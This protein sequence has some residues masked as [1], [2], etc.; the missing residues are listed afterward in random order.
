MPSIL[1]TVK[2]SGAFTSL[3]TAIKAAGLAETLNGPGP[4]TI[5]A[6]N[7]HA[8][9]RISRRT[10]E[11]LLKDEVKVKQSVAYHVIADQIMAAD[12]TK[13]MIT[14]TVQG[15]DV[16]LMCAHGF[17]I[18]EAKVVKADIVCDNGVIHMIDVVLMVPVVK[19]AARPIAMMLTAG[20]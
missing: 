8:F 19:P 15:Q 17:K 7:D 20:Q 10:L 5:F 18:N 6:P 3:I 2:A 9:G 14:K 16:T 1:E 13:L 11:T 4:F 12:V